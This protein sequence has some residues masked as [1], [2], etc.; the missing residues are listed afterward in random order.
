MS[1]AIWLLDYSIS[2]DSLETYLRWFHEVHVPEKLARTGYTWAAHYRV[3]DP[4]PAAGS[5]RFVGMFGGESPRVFLDPSPAQLKLRQSGE[6]REMMGLRIDGRST[7]YCEEWESHASGHAP[8][9]PRDLVSDVLCLERYD[10][11][12]HDEDLAAWCAQEHMLHYA[13]SAGC[14]ASRKLIASAG[15]PRHAVMHELNDTPS[16]HEIARNEP[17]SEW[18][19]RLDATVSRPLGA[20]L[21]A[22]R[23]WPT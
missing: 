3:C 15:S 16:A 20:A 11:N 4:Q 18:R 5:T 8:R 23:I 14:I 6:T 22:E 1:A 12:G 10:A 21:I 19:Q 13:G 7:V 9:S 2:D 17:T